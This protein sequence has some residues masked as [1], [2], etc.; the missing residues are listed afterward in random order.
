MIIQ[1]L[2]CFHSSGRQRKTIYLL[3][4]IVL[5]C[6]N[7]ND[8]C[9][10]WLDL[11]LVILQLVLVNKIWSQSNAS[12]LWY[13]S[14]VNIRLV[15]IPLFQEKVKAYSQQQRGKRQTRGNLCF[16]GHWWKRQHKVLT[17]HNKLKG[18]HS[19]L[20]TLSHIPWSIKLWF[21]SFFPCF[22]AVVIILK[23]EKKRWNSCASGQNWNTDN[24]FW[25][26]AQWLLRHLKLVLYNSKHIEQGLLF[27]GGLFFPLVF[28]NESCEVAG[29]DAK[30]FF[31]KPETNQ[32]HTPPCSPGNSLDSYKPRKEPRG[33]IQGE[34]EKFDQTAIVL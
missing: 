32:P 15:K 26:W 31:F 4:H 17:S 11:L 3:M 1:H 7:L 8:A 23:S 19:C 16:E 14:G 9:Y 27:C 34:F 20:C 33:K 18:K 21:G 13:F 24:S 25:V 6:G 28:L 10:S 2:D 12:F 30:I 22:L 5:P 29:R